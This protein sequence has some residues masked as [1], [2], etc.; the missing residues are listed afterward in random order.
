MWIKL[1]YTFKRM[2]E[3][4]LKIYQAKAKQ[5]KLAEMKYMSYWTIEL[6]KEQNIQAKEMH[7]R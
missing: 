1:R 5:V 7:G 2:T 3:Y 6:R 4:M